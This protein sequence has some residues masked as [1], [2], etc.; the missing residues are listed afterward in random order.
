MKF[1]NEVYKIEMPALSYLDRQKPE[2]LY[3]LV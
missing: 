3:T 2:S 1:Q